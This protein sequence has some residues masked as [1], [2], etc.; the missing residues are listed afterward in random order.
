VNKLSHFRHLSLLAATVV[1]A[2]LLG[3]CSGDR[4]ASDEQSADGPRGELMVFAAAS[5]TDGFTDIA[6]AFE[7]AHPGVKVR[8]NFAGSQSLRT[9]IE[10]GAQP[11]VFASANAKHMEALVDG[12]QVQEPRTFAHNELVLVVPEANPAGI[13][14]L[15]DLPKAKRLVLAGP[16]VPAGAYA[17]QML[18]K[19]TSLH[20]SDFVNRVHGRVVSRET[21]VRQTLQ[22]VALGEADAA[23]VYA[24]DAAAAGSKL[25]TI[26]IPA[27][28]NVIADYPIAALADTPRSELGEL[29]VQFA[30]S[31]RGKKIL[32]RHGFRP[33]GA[34]A[35]RAQ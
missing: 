17:E 16:N 24:T 15:A 26:P 10:N 20:G 33:A 6:R 2:S 23:I 3:G 9:Q 4:D 14:S 30:L 35:A 1:L 25:K 5:L 13:E 11:Q 21:H 7:K 28:V 31:D 8:L 19:A 34:L 22:K 27:E 18:S 12:G 29:F 32:D